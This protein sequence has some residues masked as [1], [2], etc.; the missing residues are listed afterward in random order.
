MLGIIGR[1]T[2]S[3]CHVITRGFGKI[4]SAATLILASGDER[5][6]DENA[7]LMMHEMSDK[8]KG[9]MSDIGVEYRHSL[10]LE[11]QMYAMY[12]KFSKEKTK[13]ATFKKLCVGKDH[14]ISAEDT[15]KLG[16]VDRIT[17]RL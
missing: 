7:W 12:E 1:I 14:Y 11:A 16:L 9:K 3:K 17:T 5:L 13:A 8:I 10:Q 2:S 6:M 15:L 4:M